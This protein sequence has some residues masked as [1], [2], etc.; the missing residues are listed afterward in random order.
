MTQSTWIGRSLGGRYQIE[1]LLGQGG[2]S[3]VYKAT[4]PNLKRVVA[5]KLIHPHLSS[6]RE[7]VRRFEEE[8]AAVAQL[9]HPNI[10]QVYDFNHDGDT[11]YIVFEFVPGETLQDRLK[12]S[13]AAE[14]PLP[15]EETIKIAANTAEA[16]R[17]AHSRGLIHRDLKPANIM[18][19]VTGQ[20][21]LM[22][23]GIVKILG[24][25]Q[26]TATGAVMG[27]ARYMSPEQI[28]GERIDARTDIYSLGVVLFEMV[29]GRPPFE[30]DSAM[31]LMMMHITDPVPDLAQIRPGVPA[32]LVA[33]INKALAKDP[34]QRYQT[35]AELVA[36]LGDIRPDGPAA[37]ATVVEQPAIDSTYVE[38]TPVALP[39][40]QTFA[41]P[42][43]AATREAPPAS[44]VP[45]QATSTAPA[46][47]GNQRLLMAGGGLLLLA[48]LL[49]AGFA[50]RGLFGGDGGTET[51]GAI[52]DVTL[53][54]T[55]DGD[56]IVAEPTDLPVG[57]QATATTEPT[58]EPTATT[59]PTA[60]T[61]PTAT[62]QSPTAEPSPTTAATATI[63]PPTHTPPPPTAPPADFSSHISN[64][65]LSDGRYIVDYSTSGY[66][67]A[68]PGMH[69]HFFF[70]TLAPENAG[71]GGP[72]PGNWFVYGG[73]RPFTGYTTNDKP[74]GATQ[75]CVLVAN[76]DHTVRAGSG[77]CFNLP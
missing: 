72:N 41:E 7:F 23:F 15:L 46:A 33:V 65:T 52:G 37:G 47:M 64:I 71:V 55:D 21:I 6:D 73:P 53:E 8:A 28:K 17:Y 13:H 35:A 57:T 27:T 31:T 69:V 38:S 34:A 59:Q 26:H 51:P 11:Y 77:N 36:A 58:N 56:Q 54:P 75:M 2:M 10:I 25:T 50:F 30:A 1:A 70:N 22:D 12:R 76:A 44:V 67:E 68:L 49:V 3:A 66:T 39:P 4:D 14:R 32:D 9:R 5:V 45:R 43:A 48:L 42:A 29:G 40:E 24:G 18:L 61:A 20:A 19:N 74:D 16:I 60:T 63:V 62:E